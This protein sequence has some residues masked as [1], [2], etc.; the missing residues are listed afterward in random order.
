MQ[1][2]RIY[3][4]AGGGNAHTEVEV[5]AAVDEDDA[6][7]KALE[8]Q[9]QGEVEWTLTDMAGRSRELGPWAWQDDDVEITYV[10]E[11]DDL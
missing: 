6:M 9:R 7:E 3:M 4:V 8:M 2:Y 10:E 11:V 1:E 5:K